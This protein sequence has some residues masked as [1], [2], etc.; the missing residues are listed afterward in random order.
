M[1]ESI[2]G[3]NHISL[4]SDKLLA[5][6]EVIVIV[7]DDPFIRE[8]LRIFLESHDLAV[9]EAGDG[10]QLRICPIPTASASFLKLLM[11]TRELP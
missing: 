5:Q 9:V 10:E 11:R 6:D 2:P 8:P 1:L 7:D 3:L 4:T